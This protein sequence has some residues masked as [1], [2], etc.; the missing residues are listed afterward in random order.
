V[1]AINLALYGRL[2]YAVPN[3][4]S[5]VIAGWMITVQDAMPAALRNSP[6]WRGLLPLAAGTGRGHEPER[7]ELVFEWLWGTVL[8]Q[9]QSAADAGGYGPAWA[10]I[11]RERTVAAAA[12]VSWVASVEASAAAAWAARATRAVEGAAWVA[13]V[14]VA[15]V[16]A[17][18]AE[19]AARA[20]RAA[21]EVAAED[22]W[23]AVD[24]VGLLQR[25]V[26]VGRPIKEDAP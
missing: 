3:C 7:V 25:L 8:P 6:E 17:A 23:S 12:E 20:A 1:A 18:A 9:L 26:E 19:W 15:S 4:M 14:E 22:Y 10:A 24:P 2:T 21:A 13:S 11:C 5:L 16:E